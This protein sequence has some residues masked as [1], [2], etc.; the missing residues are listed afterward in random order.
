ML[1]LAELLESLSL[2]PVN[3]QVPLDSV[4]E[5]Q[6]PFVAKR[7]VLLK[8]GALNVSAEEKTGFIGVCASTLG[9]YEIRV[10]KRIAIASDP[11]TALLFAFIVPAHAILTMV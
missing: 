9:K 11:K 6:E 10:A 1:T 7:I 8:S 5:V 4:I 2:K 3:V